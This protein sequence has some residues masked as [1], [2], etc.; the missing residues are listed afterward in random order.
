MHQVYVVDLHM[1]ICLPAWELDQV[2]KTNAALLHVHLPTRSRTPARGR[3]FQVVSYFILSG[4]VWI[5][6]IRSLS[7]P[8]MRCSK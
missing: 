8:S 6:S 3:S 1:Y 7:F 5:D 4:S 2:K